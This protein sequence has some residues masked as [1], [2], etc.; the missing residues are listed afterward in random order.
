MASSSPPMGGGR[1]SSHRDTDDVAWDSQMADLGDGRLDQFATDDGDNQVHGRG[2]PGGAP[3][4]H[5][6]SMAPRED[7][8]MGGRMNPWL[9]AVQRGDFRDSDY[10]AVQHLDRLDGGN[11]H[12]INKPSYSSGQ[13]QGRNRHSDTN[14]SDNIHGPIGRS[15]HGNT[16]YD[17]L[18]PGHRKTNLARRMPLPPRQG[19]DETAL[20]G[21]MPPGDGVTV[22]RW[23][24]GNR[25]DTNEVTSAT[26]SGSGRGSPFKQTPSRAPPLSAGRGRG[27][28]G[29]GPPPAVQRPAAMA[30]T[31]NGTNP[32]TLGSPTSAKKDKGASAST[33]TRRPIAL[34]LQTRPPRNQPQSQR[35]SMPRQI[36]QWDVQLRLSSRADPIPGSIAL[37]ELPVSKVVVLE[38]SYSQTV[39]REDIRLL[40]SVMSNGSS[41]RHLRRKDEGGDEIK[42]TTLVLFDSLLNAQRFT[43]D[44]NFMIDK[45]GKSNQ[46]YF[47]DTAAA[48]KSENESAEPNIASDAAEPLAPLLSVSGGTQMPYSSKHDA[49]LVAVE[50]AEGTIQGAPQD[51]AVVAQQQ[52]VSEKQATL[53]D[54]I[55]I[56]SPVRNKP[57]QSHSRELAELEN[58]TLLI[59]DPTSISKLTLEEHIVSP[60]P[61]R[62]TWPDTAN[63]GTYDGSP[64]VISTAPSLPGVPP[65]T[66][67]KAPAR[68]TNQTGWQDI[69]SMDHGS[70][71]SVATG[72]V[73]EY[74][75][76]TQ[77]IGLDSKPGKQQ[78]REPNAEPEARTALLDVDAIEA[79]PPKEKLS[80]ESLRI[81]STLTD[82]DYKG[83]TT[84]CCYLEA[85]L[86]PVAPQPNAP[87][88]KFAALQTAI[89]HI[90]H[91]DGFEYLEWRQKQK[92]SQMVYMNIL[93]RFSR[94]KRKP[95]E[96]LRLQQQ[97]Y[98][99]PDKVHEVNVMNEEWNRKHRQATPN[100]R[101][102][103]YSHEVVTKNAEQNHSF[104]YGKPA[105]DG[106]EP[107]FHLK[108]ITMFAEANPRGHSL[109]G[110]DRPR[111]DSVTARR[112]TE[113]K[114]SLSGT[115][116]QM[117]KNPANGT[118][119]QVAPG[120]YRSDGDDDDD[121]DWLPIERTT[122]T[123][124]GPGS[125]GTS[126]LKTGVLDASTRQPSRDPSPGYMVS[127]S[128]MPVAHQPAASSVPR[129]VPRNTIS[130][131]S[132]QR[133]DSRGLEASRWAEPTNHDAQPSSPSHRRSN[134]ANTADSQ[135][136]SVG[137]LA[138]QL[139]SFRFRD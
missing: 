12:R 16:Q 125:S 124:I 46:P 18:N 8:S 47:V 83:L 82:E 128:P 62:S 96:M 130:S 84:K 136:S 74:R 71:D 55:D 39:T 50:Q 40:Y 106:L 60:E 78:R 135:M 72:R 52:L 114:T 108:S 14:E 68:A 137:G 31:P 34:M 2:Y 123:P 86:K 139:A 69:K 110:E 64:K 66:Q 41:S 30:R 3:A 38:I 53:G 17:P 36:S 98:A 61:N 101:P 45:A 54:L 10:R 56:S 116:V 77:D 73:G 42:R 20:G 67:S 23:A 115:N 121:D 29:G 129:A 5:R 48:R 99:C 111:D 11:A 6:E 113:A 93:S 24:P 138:N 90:M 63:V 133:P 131:S 22:R 49:S 21:L 103:T 58:D 27:S 88:L 7:R 132:L 127:H 75:D 104:L 37:Y 97:T 107:R 76:G 15:S 13:G 87:L 102:P 134:T 65:R 109:A 112:E 120:R 59:G 89:L 79:I 94:I 119:P 81:L 80:E 126:H 117:H 91:D 28:P 51:T 9:E 1:P 95:E 70:M 43:N 4:Q 26:V 85:I 118:L 35:P 19:S 100:P 92:V 25:R 44:V 32:D 105:R 122:P 57:D 33:S